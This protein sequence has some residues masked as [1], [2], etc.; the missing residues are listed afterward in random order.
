[1]KKWLLGVLTGI[2][3]CFFLL[4]LIVGFGWYL[5]SRPPAVSSNTTLILELDGNIPEQAPP[6]I[7]GQLLGKPEQ[8]T[9][10]PLVRRIE[11]AAADQR[12]TGMMIKTSSLGIGWAK[13]Q[14]LRQTLDDFQK[15][16]KKLTA[17]LELAGTREYYLASVASKVY[18]SPVGVL[19][20]KGMRAE[21][22]FFKDGLAKLGVQADLEHI[23][24]Y[25]NFSDQ[26]TDNRMSDAFREATTSMLDSIYGNFLETVAD[27]RQKPVEEMRTTI[28]E[29]GPFEAERAQLAGLVDGLLY[30]DQVLKQLETEAGDGAFHKLDF[31][32]YRRVPAEGSAFSARKRI[33]VV[34][35][36]GTITSGEDVSNP[37][38]GGKT[39]GSETMSEVL[40]KVGKDESI[41]AVLVRIDSP[42]GDAFASDTIWR[43]MN[44]LSEKKPLVFSMSDTA[45]SG[46]YYLAMTGDTIVAEP[47]TLTGSIGIVY[48][49]LN[50]KGLYDKL[51]INK[52]VIAR[53][54]YSGMDS[55][56]GSY[57][58]QERQRVHQLMDTFYKDFV[59]KVATARKMTP[60]DVDKV[61]QGRVWTGD[62]AKQNGLIDEIGGFP[63]A[64]ALLKQKANIPAEES[65]ELVEFPKRKTLFELILSRA[66]GGTVRGIFGGVRLPTPLSEWLA[67]WSQLE[68]LAQRPLWALLPATFTFR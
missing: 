62:Q 3:L 18:L 32:D 57:T 25:K 43:K 5:Q 46:G 48:G 50:L 17:V 20:L 44:L 47:S 34:Y 39:I 11:Q 68:S 60:E 67:G 24:K 33:A 61:A 56:Y 4:F 31:D 52:E 6:D 27:A 30:E 45:A 41:K 8:L 37:L 10:V 42:G 2:F 22:M 63:R 9:L 59:K 29:T 7:A 26:F 58:P 35:A 21:V 51:G 23:G 64:L 16:G 54:K 14:Q 28:E 65:V 13:L 36:V 49:K 40:D 19:D 66:D 1:M 55:D 38:D 53:G 15:S 12:I